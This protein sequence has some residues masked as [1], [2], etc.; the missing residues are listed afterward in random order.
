MRS[1]RARR[2]VGDIRWGVDGLS[3]GKAAYALASSGQNAV[4]TA[5]I[6]TTAFDGIRS[7]MET[8]SVF[9]SI[10]SNCWRR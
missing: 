3:G 1:A 8:L 5:P 2:K 7:W 10:A 9:G 4:S 6:S